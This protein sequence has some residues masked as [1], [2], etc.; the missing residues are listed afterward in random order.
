[1]AGPTPV[2]ALIHAATM[3]T[4]GIY[5]VVRCNLLYSLS[6]AGAAV[7]AVTGL[8][9][10]LFAATIALRQNDIKKVLA[11]STVSQLGFMFVAAGLGAYTTAIFHLVMHAFFKALLFLGAGSVIHG[12]HGEQ[13]I[14]RMGG[15]KKR[16]PATHL[17]FL[18]GTLSI[19]GVP[20]LAGFFSKDEIL[21]AAW[22]H[23]GAI[24]GVLAL[25][26]VLTAVY[27]FRL[28]WLVFQGRYRGG[29][30]EKPVHESPRVMTVPLFALAVLSAAGGFLGI[31]AVFH[32]PHVFSE[33]LYPVIRIPLLHETSHA[34]ELALALISLAVLAALYAAT[35][36]RYVVREK[37]P[38]P[39]AEAKGFG[40]VLVHKYYV[41]ALYYRSVTVPL[42]W[43]AQRFQLFDRQLLDGAVNAVP[44]LTEAASARLR[45]TQQGNLGFYILGTVAGIVLLFLLSWMLQPD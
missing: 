45:K 18:V 6:A 40:K 2:S 19:A 29:P 13:D 11:Y 43:L 36:N 33:F 44:R 41:D 21:A 1:M 5:L 28:Y 12:L 20:P 26:S 14:R 39:E 34:F 8:A 22:Q 31:P 3:V 24:F 25:A 37:I 27:M 10:A 15:L 42:Q 32:L 16:L 35:R 7:V 23:S 4:A 9:T 38:A 17:T 30:Q